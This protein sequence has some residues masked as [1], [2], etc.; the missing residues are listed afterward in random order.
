M[1]ISSA[2]RTSNCCWTRV[3][4]YYTLLHTNMNAWFINMTA[5]KQKKRTLFMLSNGWWNYFK[6]SNLSH[7]WSHIFTAMVSI[8]NYLH[9]AMLFCW[10]ARPQQFIGIHLSNIYIELVSKR[11]EPLFNY[12]TAL[13]K[14]PSEMTMLVSKEMYEYSMNKWRFNFNWITKGSLNPLSSLSPILIPFR[15]EELSVLGEIIQL[16]VRNRLNWLNLRECVYHFENFLSI[17][18]QWI[19]VSLCV[20]FQIEVIRYGGFVK[21]VCKKSVVIWIIGHQFTFFLFLVEN[22]EMK[23]SLNIFWVVIILY[24]TGLE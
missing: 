14:L 8:L 9:R 6:G 21:I 23:V 11:N 22:F 1:A 5:I 2:L 17:R 4:S 12:S 15:T 19:F 7:V 13:L 3:Y 18:A 20:S 24:D 16:F 10:N